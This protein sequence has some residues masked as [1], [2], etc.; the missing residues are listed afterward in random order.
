MK[1]LIAGTGIIGVIR[2][3]VAQQEVVESFKSVLLS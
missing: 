2:E 1:F 3:V